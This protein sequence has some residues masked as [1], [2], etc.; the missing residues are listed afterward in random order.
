MVHEQHMLL[1]A[2]VPGERITGEFAVELVVRPQRIPERRLVIGRA[3]HP[4][5]GKTRPMSN[6]IALGDELFARAR[7]TKELVSKPSGA[8]VSCPGQH[9]FA[10]R[11]MQGVVEPGD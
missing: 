11:I 6:G 8:G 9:V 4:A 10:A 7:S 1:C 2:A 3:S 5:V